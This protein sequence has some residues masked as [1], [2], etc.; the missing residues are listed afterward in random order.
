MVSPAYS[1]L[2]LD[3]TYAMMAAVMRALLPTS[4]NDP[5]GLSRAECLLEFPQLRS[6]RSQC[7]SQFQL[8]FSAKP[9][10]VR[11][12]PGEVALRTPAP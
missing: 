5:S 6:S 1:A 8:S 11:V 4:Q 12:L 7:F 2:R 9:R 10:W 3:R